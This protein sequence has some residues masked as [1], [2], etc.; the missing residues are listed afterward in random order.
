MR[1]KS[2]ITR[3]DFDEHNLLCEKWKKEVALRT[4]IMGDMVFYTFCDNLKIKKEDVEIVEEGRK[5]ELP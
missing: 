4:D 5:D 2:K 1:R 3:K